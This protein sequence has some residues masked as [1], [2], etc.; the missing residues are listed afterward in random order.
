MADDNTSISRRDLL[1]YA[2]SSTLALTAGCV[3]GGDG[4]DGDD[5]DGESSPGDDG[6]D[7]G[8]GNG[9]QSDSGGTK[10]F[11]Y[12]RGSGTVTLN[13]KASTHGEDSKV[14]VQVY[15]NLVGFEPGTTELVGELA[16]GWEFE[17]RSLTFTLREGV[18]FHNGDEFTADDV[19]ASIRFHIDEDYEHFA[20]EEN[21]NPA[22]Q[23]EVGRYVSE[24]PSVVDSHTIRFDLNQVYAPFL[25]NFQSAHQV[26]YS[27]Q[28]IV[29]M[30]A[31][32][33]AKEPVGTGPFVFD[34]WDES[35]DRI[36]LTANDDYWGDG[37]HVDEVLF[38]VIPSNSTRA[39]SL[40]SGEI[41]GA[42]GLDTQGIELI[43]NSDSAE[44]RS[45]TGL[46][47]AFLAPN[48]SRFEPARDKRVRQA[49]NYAV[50]T[51][52]IVDVIFNGI[53]IQSSQPIPP[54]VWGHNDDLEPYPYDPEMA[55][56][57]LEEAGY[58]D[59]FEIKI[60]VMND[61]RPY[62]PAPVQMAEAVRSNLGD[63]GI[64]A[65]LIQQSHADTVSDILQ[66][67]HEAT[68]LGHF[69]INGDPSFFAHTLLHPQIDTDQIPEG[70]DWISWGT[71]GYNLYGMNAWANREYMN[72]VD[73]AQR[74]VDQAE[75]EGL[76][77]E[78]M[79]IAHEEAPWVF[80]NHADYIRGVH[81][82]VEGWVPDNNIQ[83][84]YLN[85]VDLP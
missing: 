80:M 50:D 46:N 15:D 75:R 59:G 77:Q 52:S 31:E 7:G 83:G 73:S 56:S 79:A 23:Q 9:D 85:L 70:Q 69:G 18:E 51:K 66:G 34:N 17:E 74:T 8:A 5:S 20:G 3:G 81:N 39:Q 14:T 13:Q 4:G 58:G 78:A 65:T 57:L 25:R 2:G 47:T 44:V 37:P 28:A 27:E 22:G 55:R 29:E 63:V 49:L 21:V 24:M 53:A 26:V 1:T 36:R 76:Y 12:A 48:L 19:R 71:E 45:Q 72:L 38:R 33:L 11:T 54:H 67:I 35:N 40:I 68:F 32:G 41:E 10:L 16:T 61:P 62:F 6:G 60:H 42:D 30:G 84:P 64:E 82:R 43:R